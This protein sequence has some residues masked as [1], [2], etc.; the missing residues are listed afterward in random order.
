MLLVGIGGSNIVL[1]MGVVIVFCE[2]GVV[3]CYLFMVRRSEK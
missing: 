3:L 1:L 2:V